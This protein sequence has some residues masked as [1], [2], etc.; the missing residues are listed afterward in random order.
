MI[1]AHPT[2]TLPAWS[3]FC[4]L[5]PAIRLQ[6]SVEPTVIFRMFQ[7]LIG[8][9]YIFVEQ[10]S[11]P[12]MF[13]LTLGIKHFAYTYLEG[14]ILFKHTKWSEIAEYKGIACGI[15][16]WVNKPTQLT[17][18]SGKNNCCCVFGL[19]CW[20]LSCDSSSFKL[21]IKGEIKPS[22][23]VSL[24]RQHAWLSKT[25]LCY[26]GSMNWQWICPWGCL[27]FPFSCCSEED[28]ANAAL[29]LFPLQVALCWIPP[30]MESLATRTRWSMKLGTAWG[31]ITSSGE[32]LRSS[33][34]VIR[35]WKLSPPLRPG[36]SA[37]TPTLL[38]STSCVEILGL[39]MTHVDFTVS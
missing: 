9:Y 11:A 39:A 21:Q 27:P 4:F 8:F 38:P 14:I 12:G 15:F 29:S 25:S 35:A 17:K 28:K 1:R 34:A 24:S 10:Q 6:I 22:C 13:C 32:S 16:L 26:R 33:P 3:L 36:T 20:T 19:G 31:S 5:C 23:A 30:F 18:F 2:K 7:K 37:V